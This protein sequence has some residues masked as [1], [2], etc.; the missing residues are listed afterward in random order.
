M[1]AYLPWSWV[2][3]RLKN[4][5]VINF[6]LVWHHRFHLNH[7]GGYESQYYTR[8]WLLNTSKG[9]VKYGKMAIVLYRWIYEWALEPKSIK[10]YVASIHYLSFKPLRRLRCAVLLK[11]EIIKL[12]FCSNNRKHGKM[13]IL[14]DLFILVYNKYHVSG[15]V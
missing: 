4:Q 3:F 5:N 13:A 9:V 2:L 7:F 11:I 10:A 8:T 14:Y 12:I 15:T 6:M 1:E